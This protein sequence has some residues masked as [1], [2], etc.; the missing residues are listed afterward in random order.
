MQ[1]ARSTDIGEG[2]VQNET[3]QSVVDETLEDP[4]SVDKISRVV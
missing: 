1:E 3:D 2:K 4:E